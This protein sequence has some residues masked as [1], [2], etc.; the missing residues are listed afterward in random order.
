MPDIILPFE[1]TAVW[2][3]ID[4]GQFLRWECYPASMRLSPILV[5]VFEVKEELQVRRYEDPGWV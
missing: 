4:G 3:G 5:V 1:G 2:L